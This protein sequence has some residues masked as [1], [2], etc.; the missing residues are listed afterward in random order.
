MFSIRRLL[1]RCWTVS[2]KPNPANRQFEETASIQTRDGFEIRVAVPDA[3]TVRA[4]FGVPLARRGIQ[5]VWIRITNQTDHAWRL[6]CIAVDP[7]YFSP[8][9]AAAR[10]YLRPDDLTIFVVGE[11]D[12]LEDSLKQFGPVRRVELE[13]FGGGGGRRRGRG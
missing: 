9:E 13:D 5:P 3:G 8:L 7:N 12:K 1:Q 4:F 2:Y 10:N 11:A 6:Q